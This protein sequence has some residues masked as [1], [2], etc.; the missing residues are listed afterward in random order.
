MPSHRYVGTSTH[1]CGPLTR[2]RLVT[3]YMINYYIKYLELLD[4]VFLVLRKKPL[5]EFPAPLRKP[6][7]ISQLSCTCSTTPRQPCCASPSSKAR[8]P[9]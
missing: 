6:Q 4:T 3:L 5:G 7:L 8:P 2:Q 9:L 1:Y